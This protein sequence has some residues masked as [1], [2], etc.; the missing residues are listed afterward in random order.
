MR[1][2]SLI[3]HKFTGDINLNDLPGSGRVD[4]IARAI[5]ASLFLSHDI[6]RDV[7]F[8]FYA[9]RAAFMLKID[10]SR[11]RYLNPDERSTAALIRNAYMNRERRDEPSPGFFVK[12]IDFTGFIEELSSI[13]AVFYLHEDGRDIREVS[14]PENAVFI[15]SDSVNLSDEE[16]KEVMRIARERISVGP[17]SILASHAICVVNNELDRRGI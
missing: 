2:F 10:G 4:V 17:K 16:E 8:Y 1:I 6:R 15:L 5:N 12:N 9:P 7:I 14:I 13:G 3:A 11:V